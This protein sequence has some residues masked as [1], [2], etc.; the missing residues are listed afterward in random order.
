MTAG[1]YLFTA[2]FPNPMTF[3]K[4]RLAPTPN[5]FIHLGN[6]LS[7]L[8]TSALARQ[9]GAKILL[10]IDDLDKE[11][12]KKKYV[13]DIFQTLEFLE[14][15]YDE[16]P[17]NMQEY[18]SRFSQHHRLD[19]YHQALKHLQSKNLLFACD[20]SRRK[21]SRN[22]P[23]GSYPGTCE[24][25]KINFDLKEVSWR[26]YTDMQKEIII[27]DISGKKLKTT[28]PP[29]LR[30]FVVKRKDNLPAYQL[31]T[32][33]DD[34]LDKIDFIVRGKDL[35]GSSI[36]QEYLTRKMYESSSGTRIFHHH[37]L[38]ADSS[39]KKLSK[40]SGSTSIQHLRKSGKNKS[41]I[42]GM[43]AEFLKLNTPV[44]CFEEFQQFYR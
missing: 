26:F 7:F 29:L 30:D 17:K 33:V 15:P 14:I 8:I 34:R 25:K 1:F 16:G 35:W 31:A 38:L 18:K 10:R 23:E 12:V 41:D 2:T 9:K 44:S 5:G 42:Y 28:V 32:V 11:R 36:A 4:T 43:I 27:N 24:K 37:T 22:S 3:N 13:E 20:C 6:V 40:S 39:N 21:I 19:H